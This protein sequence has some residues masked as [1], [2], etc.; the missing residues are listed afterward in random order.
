MS[1]KGEMGLGE[2]MGMGMVHNRIGGTGRCTYEALC[3]MGV[4]MWRAS[5]APVRA[6]TVYVMSRVRAAH[7]ST[8]YGLRLKCFPPSTLDQ[9]YVC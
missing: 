4:W 2:R 3:C 8:A 5:G 9:M 1:S 7:P 6:G